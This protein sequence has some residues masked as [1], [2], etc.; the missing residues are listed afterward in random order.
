MSTEIASQ[1]DTTQRSATG[2]HALLA[3]LRGA[4]AKYL[5]G[6]PGHGA[7]PIYDAINDFDDLGTIVGRNEQGVTFAALTYAWITGDVAVATS[8]PEAGLTNAATSLLEATLSQDRLLFVIEAD[9]IHKE[10][11][12]AIGR[13][14]LSV[15]DAADIA[16]AA[17]ELI[18]NLR[19]RRPGAAILEITNRALGSSASVDLEAA[20]AAPPVAAPDVGAVVSALREAE[21]VAILT[22]ASAVSSGASAVVQAIAE[23]LDAPVMTDGF[24]KGVLPETHPLALGHTWTSSGPGEDLLQQCDAIL[25]IG[26]PVAAAQ[27][28]AIWDPQMVVGRRPAHQLAQQLLLVDWD[29][30]ALDLVPA[31]ARA[32]GHV[33][34]ILDEIK[35]GLTGL[36]DG[37]DRTTFQHD[38]TALDRI[39][40]VP[41]EYAKERIPWA[42]DMLR[43]LRSVL[44]DD[45]IVLADSLVGIWIERLHT[46]PGPCRMRFPWGTGTLGYGIPA[47]VGAKLAAPENNVVVVAGDGA[48]LYNP[49]E[50]ATLRLYDQ[51]VT[52]VVMNDN[53]Y[54]AIK[55]NMTDAFG[56]STAHELVNPDFTLLGKA[57]GFES[58]S[59]GSSDELPTALADAV[60]DNR[61]WLIEV[62]LEL[63]PPKGLFDWAIA[64]ADVESD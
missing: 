54:S 24:S 2:A 43:S 48:A 53:C 21:K 42:A 3:A 35:S 44:P 50:L 29:G 62:P 31:R 13:Y 19:T 7:Y 9:P 11:A 15:D 18:G 64:Y 55:H 5:F 56:R 14:Y 63:L 46:V 40:A 57:F 34:S 30:H 60:A 38:P 4:G 8:V 37:A 32:Y 25:V 1:L 23:L 45:T 41:V 28:T 49:Q 47:A 36:R 33:P 52:V 58:R 10:I 59:L 20:E 12:S 61:S 6:V 26:A 16:P 17:H 27:N 39:R 51:K 22:G